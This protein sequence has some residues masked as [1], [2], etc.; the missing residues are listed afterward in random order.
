MPDNVRAGA[1]TVVT[2]EV[3]F[4]RFHSRR[5]PALVIGEH[6]TM[7]GVQFALGLDGHVEIGDYC[8][9]TNAVLLCE[10][11]LRIGRYVVIGWNTT[12]A[13][14]DFHPIA[15]AAAHRRRGRLFAARQGP[16]PAADPDARGRDRGR[17]VDR[18]QRHH[19]EGRAHRR[20]VVHRTR[21]AGDPDVPP[22]SRVRRQSR[23]GG[24]AR[25]DR[26][27]RDARC[28][29]TGIRAPFRPTSASAASAYIET[30][31]SFTAV[32]RRAARRGD[33]RRRRV[34]LPGHDVRRRAASGR[35]ALGDYALVHGAR[36]IC[37]IGDRPSTTTRWSRGTWC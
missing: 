33:D 19:P 30:T 28:R 7:D 9:F 37:D 8:Y 15:P 27:D 23:R 32:P 26:D 13:D 10:L 11:T 2:G 3:A 29:G 24:R 16:R 31:F 5:T 34:D 12:I 20:R 21:R 17:R 6:C 14:T 36:I 18:P 22:R 35:V 25:Y 1:G 4:K